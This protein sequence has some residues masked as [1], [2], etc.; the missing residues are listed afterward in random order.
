MAKS[1]GPR[2]ARHARAH[3]ASPRSV[4]PRLAGFALA[5]FPNP[6]ITDSGRISQPA[7]RHHLPWTPRP[8]C[9]H[10]FFLR[11]SFHRI[12]FAF[13][14][15]RLARVWLFHSAFHA[16]KE[17]ERAPAPHSPRPSRWVGSHRILPR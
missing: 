4:Q 17:A 10:R 11:F 2:Q 6:R 7:A 8:V 5:G 13:V 15:F 16:E 1:K 3:G 9:R 14:A 12:R